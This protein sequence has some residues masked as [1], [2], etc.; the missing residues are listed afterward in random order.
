MI[1]VISSQF[2]GLSHIEVFYNPSNLLT[3]P[4]DDSPSTSQCGAPQWCLLLGLWN[5]VATVV[6]TINHSEIGVMWTPTCRDFVATGA[7][8]C[9]VT[10]FGFSMWRHAHAPGTRTHRARAAVSRADWEHVGH[11]ST[12]DLLIPWYF[13]IWRFPEIGVPPVIIHFNGIVHNKP[14]IWGYP[15]YG[16]PH[17]DCCRLVYLLLFTDWPLKHIEIKCI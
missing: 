1:A 7:P 11:G 17:I 5:L 14:P 16:N 2:L 8:L 4:R 10:A 13:A 3:D 6:S 9:S 12:L 15:F